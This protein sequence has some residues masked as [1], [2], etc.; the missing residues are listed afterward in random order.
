IGRWWH[1]D[2]EIDIVALN[3]KTAEIVFC[4]CK[5]QNRETGVGVLE[6]L[7]DKSKYVR[8]NDGVRVEQFMVVS[9]SGFTRKAV[10]YARDHNFILLTP[11]GDPE[12]FV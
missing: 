8:W 3:E 11:G 2:K 7:L 5:W 10:D 4:E 12:N 1:K 9:R 6:D